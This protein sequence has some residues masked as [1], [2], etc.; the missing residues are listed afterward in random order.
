MITAKDLDALEKKY[1]SPVHILLVSTDDAGP[2]FI[3]K[4]GRAASKKVIN[5]HGDINMLIRELRKC[6]T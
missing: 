4:E 2:L 6:V 3:L 5:M 1:F